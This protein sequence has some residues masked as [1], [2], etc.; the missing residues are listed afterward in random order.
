[1]RIDAYNQIAHIYSAHS[2]NKVYQS[3]R[4]NK[5]N[6]QFLISAFGRDYTVAKK[7]VSESQ[8]VREDKVEY[9]RNQIQ[10]GEYHVDPSDFASKL[11]DK[12][13]SV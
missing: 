10:T 2:T 1:M 8:D 12:I 7:A 13:Q 6:D 3:T 4:V 11:L 5:G 9:L